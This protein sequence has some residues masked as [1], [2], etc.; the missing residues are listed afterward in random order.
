MTPRYSCIALVLGLILFGCAQ[1]PSGPPAFEVEREIVL[2]DVH[3]R[4]DH[5]AIDSAHGRLAVAELENRSVDIVNISDGAVHRINDVAEPQGV[6]FD[7]TGALLVVA[8]RVSGA[9]RLFDSQTLAP[10][11]SIRLGTD[12]DNVRIDPRNNHAIVGYGD[13]ALGVVDLHTKDVLARI[14]LPAHP[15][16]FQV[17]P[18]SGRIF[19]N[20]PD[21]RT[22]GVVDLDASTLLATWRLPPL[23]WNYPMA[24]DSASRRIA[25]AFRSPARVV[26][27]STEG[28]VLASA[29]LCGDSDDLF[30]DELRHRLYAAC[31]DGAVNVLEIGAER[32][33][34]LGATVTSPGART[35][36]FVPDL[37]RL[38]VA[39][40]A[41]AGQP[42]TIIVL[43][44]V[45]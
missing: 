26:L 11:A 4:I 16:A 41:R 10:V 34:M 36:L 1:A 13:G 40:P 44:P 5:L 25:V 30:F 18:R 6:A 3:G 12:A 29:P 15:E 22:I 8:E 24:I 7:Q 31:G 28:A 27:F 42:A 38:F 32:P 9:L 33:R 21:R 37:D 2:P 14:A 43:R 45:G 23:L 39:A 17:D 20:L 35:A 19:I